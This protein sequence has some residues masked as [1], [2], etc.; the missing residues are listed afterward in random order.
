MKVQK[1]QIELELND[2]VDIVNWFHNPPY[3]RK[4]AKERKVKKVLEKIAKQ[5]DN[6]VE[7]L[8]H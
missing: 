5:V 4:K 7:A 8:D 6:I 1:V 3:F 2:A